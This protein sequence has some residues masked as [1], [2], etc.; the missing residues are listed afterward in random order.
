MC[1]KCPHLTQHPDPAALQFLIDD[2]AYQLGLIRSRLYPLLHFVIVEIEESKVTHDSSRMFAETM[3]VSIR[4]LRDQIC[5]V[6]ELL[7]GRKP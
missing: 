7:Q 1:N 4:D 3:L 6:H 5:D 2:A